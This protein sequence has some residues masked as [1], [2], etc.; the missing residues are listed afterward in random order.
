MDYSIVEV[1]DGKIVDYDIQPIHLSH[2]A[3]IKNGDQVYVIQHPRGGSLA[4]SSSQ[5]IVESVCLCVC[6][7][8]CVYVCVCTIHACA[9]GYVFAL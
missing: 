5:S 9:H 3:D 1:D 7:C 2:P 4:F 8:V 6:V